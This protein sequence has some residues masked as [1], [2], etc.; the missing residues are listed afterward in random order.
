MLAS[1]VAF[2]AQRPMRHLSTRSL[3]CWRCIRGGKD[4]AALQFGK[5]LFVELCRP[6]AIDRVPQ[7]PIMLEHS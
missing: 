1:L 6:S 7:R 3:S 5:F 2:P 4:G